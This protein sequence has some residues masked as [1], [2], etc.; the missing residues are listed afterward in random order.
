MLKRLLALFIVAAL[1]MSFTG[2]AAIWGHDGGHSVSQS[3][4]EKKEAVSTG[5]F[6]S[7]RHMVTHF[8]IILDGLNDMH[9]F[10][11]RHFMN[12]DWDDPYYN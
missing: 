1:V 3:L 12:Y 7:Q 11:D 5:T 4:A 8:Q 9:K 2:C 10:W 6:H